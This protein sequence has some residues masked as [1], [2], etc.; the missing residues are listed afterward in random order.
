MKRDLNIKVHEITRVEGHGNI[1]I[2]VKKGKIRDL[3]LEIIESPRFFEMMLRGRRYD[4]AQHIMARICA[5]THPSAA[6][7]AIEDAMDIKI[8]RQ[9]TLLRKLAF[10]GEML[11]SHIL[12][13]FFLVVPDLV[14]AGSIV[15]LLSSHPDIAK[16]GLELKRLANEICE[17][18]GGRHK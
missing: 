16:T 9:S 12:H 8:S 7:R 11:Q 5:G 15:P 1:V 14:G 13:V 4:E 18:V 10:D 6:L 17:I 2:D 3:K